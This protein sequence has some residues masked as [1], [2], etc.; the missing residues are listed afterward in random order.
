MAIKLRRLG[1]AAV[2]LYAALTTYIG[3]VQDQIIREQQHELVSLFGMAMDCASD[4]DSSL[5]L[6]QK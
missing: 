5:N 4:S 3:Y 6:A 2:V 1:V